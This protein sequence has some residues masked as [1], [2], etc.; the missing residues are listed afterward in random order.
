MALPQRLYHELRNVGARLTRFVTQ[1]GGTEMKSKESGSNDLKLLDSLR[2]LADAPLFI[3]ANLVDRFYDAIVQPQGEQNKTVLE[4]TK[5]TVTKLSGEIAVG[6]SIS[7]SDLLTR[8]SGFLPFLKVEA[9]ADAKGS[10]GRDTTKGES[11]TIEIFTIKTPQRQLVNLVLHYLVNQPSRLYLNGDPSDTS[12]RTPDFVTAVPRALVFLDLPG[13]ET[14]R[15][16]PTAAEFSNGKVVTLFDQFR[17]RDGRQ[18]PPDYTSTA[19][20][21]EELQKKRLEYWK[22]FD[23]NFDATQAME[24]VEE[25]AGANGRIRWIDFRLPVSRVGDTLHLHLSPAEGYDTGSFAYQLVK[26]GYKH[27]LRLVGTLKSEP[28]MNVLAVYEK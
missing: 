24:I 2:W 20:P 21:S 16:I 26:R 19:K 7:P 15:L 1:T 8:L 27:G 5:E 17:S 6:G 18:S 12:W 9:H 23:D 13:Q 10:A 4:V 3:D 28:D 14:T 22:W 25:A 11:S